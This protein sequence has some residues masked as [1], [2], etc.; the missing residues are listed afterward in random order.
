MVRMMDKDST[1][2]LLS[3]AE[4]VSGGKSRVP[5]VEKNELLHHLLGDIALTY[6][7]KID[8]DADFVDNLVDALN[9]GEMTEAEMFSDYVAAIDVLF[10]TVQDPKGMKRDIWGFLD[11][12][13]K[14]S[15][16]PN[17]V[18]GVS[19]WA[20]AA[21]SKAK[22]LSAGGRYNNFEK[23]RA[24]YY[25]NAL[26]A[27]N[28]N[29]TNPFAEANNAA[30]NATNAVFDNWKRSLGLESTG[31]FAYNIGK[32]LDVESVD[33]ETVAVDN[34]KKTMSK[35]FSQNKK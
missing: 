23:A 29:T 3:K 15:P 18:N 32:L 8:S 28:T 26:G 14:K 1:Q 34:A 10:A 30:G 5:E 35:G 22:S 25:R 24:T 19:T 13:A 7:A 16:D 27:F 20:R 31:S 21:A 4:I 9:D 17:V 2:A 11:L 12:V 6:A 33:Q